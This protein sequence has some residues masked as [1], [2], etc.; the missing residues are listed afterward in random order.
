[1][2]GILLTIAA[3][4]V[5]LL[6]LWLAQQAREIDNVSGVEIPETDVLPAP[7]SW[8]HRSVRIRFI[9]R[10]GQARIMEDFL[11]LHVSRYK[12]GKILVHGL[13]ATDSGWQPRGCCLDQILDLR[14]KDTLSDR[15]IREAHVLYRMLVNPNI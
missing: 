13:E 11:V 6:S 1:M 2:L 9:K 5:V 12:S 4:A 15:E 10:D 7:E 8:K 3:V 14:V